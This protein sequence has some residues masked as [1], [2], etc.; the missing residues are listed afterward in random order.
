V[1]LTRLL[2]DPLW[3]SPF[4]FDVQMTAPLLKRALNRV[5]PRS[6]CNV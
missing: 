4:S 5:V 6:P 3:P 1:S 2:R